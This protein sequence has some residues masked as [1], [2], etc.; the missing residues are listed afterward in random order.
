MKKL[1]LAFVL[2]CAS[3]YAVPPCI[4]IVD[5]LYSMGPSGNVLMTG[6]IEVKLGFF[7]SNGAF[8]ITASLMTLPISAVTNNL[9]TCINPATV[10]QANYTVTTGGRTP[11]KYTTYWY[12]PNTGG[13]YQL[14]SVPTGVVNVSGTPGVALWSSG[15]NFA[16]VSPND[17]VTINGV[18]TSAASVQSVTQLTLLSGLGTLTNATFSAGPVERGK[19]SG[20][21]LNPPSIYGPQGVPGNGVVVGTPPSSATPCAPP[22]MEF[23]SSFIYVCVA[24][25]TWRRAATSSF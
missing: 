8:T 6:Y 21:G 18:T 16:L 25:D 13:P 10:V 9:S 23:D 14:T 7:T 24:T 2:A 20:S 1:L 11:V 17:P 3:S 22:L 5:T 15:L 4:P 19:S 12:V